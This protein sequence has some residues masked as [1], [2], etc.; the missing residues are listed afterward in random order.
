MI[1]KINGYEATC[2]AN[3]NGVSLYEADDKIYVVVGDV[4]LFRIYGAA[5][6]EMAVTLYDDFDGTVEFGSAEEQQ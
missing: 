6:L 5:G 1:S 4:V 3:R 2:V